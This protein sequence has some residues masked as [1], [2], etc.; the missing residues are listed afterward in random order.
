MLL[1]ILSKSGTDISTHAALLT[2]V[3]MTTVCWLL[4]AYFGP[5]TDRASLIGFYKKV[6][7]FGPG[8]RAIRRDAGL[9][10]PDVR[11]GRDNI[12]LA[13]L[14]WTAGSALVWSGL[15]AIGNFLYGRTG[16]GLLLLVVVGLTGSV[17]LVRMPSPSLMSLA[18]LLAAATTEGSSMAMGTM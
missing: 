18:M 13:L 4:T 3:A 11:M 14:G 1:L 8:W 10:E 16:M 7:P 2:T 12:P 5:Q 15:F 6:K 17:L 9:C